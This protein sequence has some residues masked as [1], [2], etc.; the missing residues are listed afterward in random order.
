MANINEHMKPWGRRITQ[1]EWD[2]IFNGPQ[3]SDS[4]QQN[5]DVDPESEENADVS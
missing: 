2:A 5:Q 4:K 3:K 1:E